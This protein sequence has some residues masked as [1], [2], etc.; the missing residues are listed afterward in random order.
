[1][2]RRLT[3]AFVL[4]GVVFVVS[5]AALRAYSLAHLIRDQEQEHLEHDVQVVLGIVDKVDRDTLPLLLQGMAG[6][7]QRIVVLHNG[8][9]LAKVQGPSYAVPPGDQPLLAG[10]SA[11]GYSVTITEGQGGLRT[12]VR[13]N[14][15]QLLAVAAGLLVLTAFV[16]SWLAARM[17]APF[18]KLAEAADGLGRGRFELT[19]PK[20]RVPEANAIARALG[21]SARTLET[22]L[23]AERDSLEAASHEIRTPLTGL[24][25]ELEDLTTRTDV[26]D[27]VRDTAQ[28][29]LGRID[30]ATE[31]ATQFIG[32]TRRRNLVEGARAPLSVVA[33][34]VANTWDE[35]LAA[36]GVQ[37]RAFVDG[38]AE[39]TPGPLE[40]VLEEVLQGLDHVVGPVSM[41][42]SSVADLVTVEVIGAP[43][44]GSEALDRA[45]G[46]AEMVGGVVTQDLEALRVRLPAR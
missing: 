14:V 3:A 25:M 42:V 17:S 22:R 44:L 43:Q 15:A 30:R 21:R 34:R 23:R 39:I 8:I 20:T 4:I 28:R 9:E 11:N 16:G 12:L 13:S 35:R 31:V 1:M 40:Q 46:L 19:L 18:G 32:D 33:E 29:A 37:F 41:S 26:P 45:R 6:T 2:R 27:D 7:D 36:L 10:D 5:F 24:R 38:D